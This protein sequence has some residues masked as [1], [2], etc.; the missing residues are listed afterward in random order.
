MKAMIDTGANRTFIS[1][2]ALSTSYSKQFINA[3]QKTASLADGHTSISILGALDLH[4]VIGDMSTSI[5][6]Y[7]VKDLCAECI[8]GMDFISK[9]KFII[10]ADERVISL[11]DHEKRIALEYDVNQDEI[12]YPA[13]TIRYTYIPPQGTVSIPVNIGISSAKVSFRPSYQLA[14]QSSMILL[15]N[16]LTVNQQK[17]HI[18]IYNPTSY[19]YTLPKG[20]I[21]GTTTV[22]TLSFSKCTS[23]NRELVDDYINKLTRHIADLKQGEEI[24]AILHQHEKL[25]DTSK[26][27]VA[28][29]VKPHEIKTLDHPP[30]SS[31]PYRSTPDKEEEMYKIVQD[32]LHN[33]LIRKSYSPYAAPALLVA[34]HDGSWRMVVDFKK[35]NNLTIKD[36]YPLPNMEQTIRRLDGGY[37]FFSKLDMKSGFWQIPIK[38]GDRH[39]TAFVTVDGLYEWNVLAQG[40][41]NSPPSFQRVMADI[42]APCRQFSLVYIDDIVVFS[43]SFEEHLDHIRQLL[44]ILSKYNFQLNP[45]KCKLFHQKIDY[46]SHIISEEGF[47]PNN[48]RIQSIMNL[49]EPSTLVEANKFLGGLSWYRK[50]VPRFASIA[51]PIHKVTNLTKQNRKNFK[52]EQPQHEAFLRLKQFLVTTPLFLDYPNDNYPVILTT[53]AS[54]I[55]IGGTLQQNINGEIKNL[56]YHSQ[57]TSST[58]KRYDPIELEALAIWMCFQRMRPYLLGRSVIIYTDHCPLCNMMNS[59]VKNRRVDR[60]SILL[61][62]YDI[63]KIIHIKGQHNCL[64]DYLS[65]HPIPREEEIFDEDYGIAEQDKGEPTVIECVPDETPPLAGAITRSETK[66]LR[67]EQDK[68][69]TTITPSQKNV[70]PSST[71]EEEEDDQGKDSASQDI[72]KYRFDM[73]QLKIEQEKDPVIQQKIIEVKKN[74][75]KCSY[76]LKDGLLYKLLMMRVNCNTKKKIIYLPSSMIN[77]LLQVY[78][79]DPL[80][81]HFG[82]QRTYLKIKNIFWWPDMK[83]SITRYIQSCLPCQQYNITRTKKPGRL[84]PIPPPEGPFQLI[85]MDYCGPLKQTPS[86]N[87]YVL[88]ITDYFTRWIVAVAVPDCS[89]QT[90]AEAFFKEYICKYGVPAVV[91]SDQGTHF[92]NQLMEAMSKLVGYDHT[93]STTY[94]PQSNGMIERFN[95]TFIPQIAKLQDRENNNWDEF[96]APVVFAYNTGCHSTTQYSPFQLLFGRE[97]RLPTEAPLSTFT[98]RKPNDYYEQLKK[99][100]KLIHQNAHRNITNKQHQYKTR[101]DKQRADPHYS[102]NDRV[103]IRKHG[104]KNK[105]EPKYSITPQIIIQ[106]KHPVYVVKDETT[107]CETQVHINDIKPIYVSKSN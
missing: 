32:L 55:G 96:L 1:L 7:V 57:V 24:K 99:S 5:K 72:Q 92:H 22:P 25:F 60:I 36:N 68:N 64:A 83:Q 4:I 77:N 85:G 21:L 100:M 90:T 23:I 104:L 2:Q 70:T 46:L 49:R 35:L 88:C 15:N 94:H 69:T 47:Q 80:S 26:P 16:T 89:A 97:A 61:Q 3:K 50:F 87:Q 67:L 62:E 59:T 107:Q 73:E 44:S 93:Y 103:L 28:I 76:E 11:C 48:D 33:G 10:N 29:N 78:H 34:K 84:Q 9:Y 95:A 12:C 41:K 82:V 81:G 38:E 45:P 14:Q 74:P 58:Q 39:K 54:K 79:S 18:S 52:W 53:D 63:E 42:L 86:G 75:V 66:K 6:G 106:E 71:V 20:V 102:I 40:L 27:A 19:F 65:R 30:P 105:L 37:K 101:Y 43:R 91:L 13:R 98:F 8:L 56:Y 31:R 51:A 17:S